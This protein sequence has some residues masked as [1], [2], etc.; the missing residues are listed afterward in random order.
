[1]ENIERDINEYLFYE[2]GMDGDNDESLISET[3]PFAL[4]LVGDVEGRLVYEFDEDEPF[5]A[6]AKPTFNFLLKK[7][8]SVG[9][10][11]LQFLGKDWI[12]DQDPVD[13]SQ[14]LLSDTSVPSG[15]ERARALR[16]LG[17]QALGVLPE[18]VRI[19]EGLYLR[20]KQCYLGLFSVSNTV[21]A[22]IVGL[23]SLIHVNYPEWS[24][25]QRLGWGVGKWLRS[26]Q[27]I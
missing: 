6:L 12:A 14:S 27:I 7:G 26:K 2:F 25:W 5:F 4:K 15:L 13:L 23:D 19:L 17:A 16:T 18:E 20:S 1:M 8:M 3:W 11:T 22:T 10:L 24:P 21:E 9:D